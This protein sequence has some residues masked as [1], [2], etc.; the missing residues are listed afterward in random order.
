MRT[1]IILSLWTSLFFIAL[2]ISCVKEGPQGPP[3]TNGT[4][5]TNGI[6]GVDG[7]DGLDGNGT[8]SSCHFSGTG[9]LAKQVQYNNSVH[10]ND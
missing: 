1:P 9:L 6:N 5:G 8:C 7:V 10:A 4:N 3:G 2:M